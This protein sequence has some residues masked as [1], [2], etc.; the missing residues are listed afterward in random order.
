MLNLSL[1]G[2][3]TANL[4]N[5]PITHFYSQKARAL[6]IYLAANL[7][8]PQYRSH[9]AGLLWPEFTEKRARRN[10]SQALTALRKDLGSVELPLIESNTHTIQLI[11]DGRVIVDSVLFE[12]GLTAVRNHDHSELTAC[13]ACTEALQKTAV[14][15]RG[16]FLNQIYLSDSAIF[17]EWISARREYYAQK[18]I[19]ILMWLSDCYA[20]QNKLES[21]LETTDKLLTMRPWLE[22]AHQQR[23]RL[24]AQLGQRTQ[25]LA[26]YDLLGDALMDELGVSPSNKTNTLY[27][28]ILANKFEVIEKKTHPDQHRSSFP[29]HAPSV[30][31][32]FVG[33]R[34]ELAQLQ[35]KIEGNNRQRIAIVGMGGV[36]KTTFAAFVA[37]QL[38]SQFTDGV[39]WGN[40]KTSDPFNTLEL[41][42]RAFGN[43]FSAINDLESKAIAVRDMLANKQVLIVIDNVDDAK[44]ARSLLPD[45]NHNLTLITTRN[46]EIALALD[47]IPIFLNELDPT[48]SQ[49]LLN[50]IVG[51]ERITATAEEESAATKIVERLHHLPLAVEIAAKR[52]LSRP[53]LRLTKLAQ[54]LEVTHQRLSL[55]IGDQAVQTSFQ[56]SWESIEPPVQQIF[57]AMGHF[58]GRPFLPEALASAVAIDVQDIEDELHTLTAL[59]LVSEDGEF[60]YRQ[61]P[62]LADFSVEKLAMTEQVKAQQEFR[63]INY[64]LSFVQQAGADFVQLEPEW[65]QITAVIQLAHQ[66][67]KAQEL[68]D[69]ADSLAHVWSLRG[70]YRQAR[71]AYQLALEAAQTLD[72]MD[73]EALVWLRW[74][75]SCLEQNDYADAEIKL[76]ESLNRY[77]YIEDEEGMVQSQIHLSRIAV[78][79]GK[80]NKAIMWLNKCQEILEIAP[81]KKGL[82]DVYFYQALIAFA[83]G[84]RLDEADAYSAKALNLYET[85]DNQTSKIDVLRMQSDIATQRK[86]FAQAEKLAL[87]A[88]TLSETLRDETQLA[89]SLYCLT[90]IFIHQG[91]FEQAKTAA[92]D[93]LV[94]FRRTGIKR[95]EGLVL[96]NLSHL[97]KKEGEL[98]NAI[99]CIEKSLDIFLKLE[100]VLSQ[101]FSY[102]GLAQL[103]LLLNNPK[104]AKS[105]TNAALQLATK[106]EHQPLLD[107]IHQNL[108]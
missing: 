29:F 97:H 78:E 20:H 82:G 40:N 98:Q 60:R 89:T 73:Q 69:L 65:E 91:K 43:D 9:L 33:R 2:S 11:T 5:Q 101:A 85:A 52:L 34:Q 83:D 63:L 51:E 37:K 70:H 106:L 96:R 68:L 28:Q 6:L 23:M 56:V 26:Q 57:S 80:Y 84:Y 67:G 46:L 54:S 12:Q 71:Q 31:T 49:Q 59:S 48:Y 79:Q 41:W 100:L 39:L 18:T 76:T 93:S 3:F 21:A 95:Y 22:S 86:D 88:K 17:E 61:H 50:R 14:L 1:L 7:G 94:I 25:A 38:K 4:N 81:N 64:Y 99:E 105:A 90:T 16:P 15:Y 66:N 55:E 58:A 87:S 74:G 27:D 24:L 42:A 8:S 19:D 92:E 30:S 103:H 35:Q 62:L 53:R 32:H 44:L 13:K 104:A 47:A 75:Q 72:D 10:L 107:R 77:H 36:G 45:G 108:L 102:Y